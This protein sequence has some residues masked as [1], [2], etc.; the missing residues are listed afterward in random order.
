ML[1]PVG[2]MWV[3]LSNKYCNSGYQYQLKINIMTNIENVPNLIY[4]MGIDGSGKSTVSEYLANKFR[5]EGYDV[6]VVWLR[7][8]H[9]ITKPLL[10]LCRLIGLTK[11]ETHDGIRVGYHD[12]YKS[13]VISFLFILLQYL[14]AV[15]VKYTKILP[16]LKKTNHI[17][18]LDRYVYDI[19]IDLAVD[20]RKNNLIYSWFGKKF[21]DL[22]PKDS[23]TILVRRDLETVLDVRPEGRV[24]RN[25]ES[26]YKHYQQ[27]G[28]NL[29]INIINNEGTLE[30]L[31]SSAIKASGLSQ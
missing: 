1:T 21:R 25:F 15:R 28:D 17:I 23:I 26:R 8:N 31:L 13:S 22:L 30:E 6:D 20:T 16:I 4:V 9:V 3:K 19:L 29:G 24:D 5:A 11:Y 14:D 10:G 12:F 2:K 18:I 7:F 27:L